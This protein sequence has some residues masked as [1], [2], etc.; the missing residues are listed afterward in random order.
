[1]ASVADGA[2]RF[3]RLESLAIELLFIISCKIKHFIHNNEKNEH[4]FHETHEKLFLSEE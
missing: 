4:L 2:S 1:M 3:S